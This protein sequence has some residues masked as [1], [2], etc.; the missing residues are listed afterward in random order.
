MGGVAGLLDPGQGTH[1]FRIQFWFGFLQE[2]VERRGSREA[3]WPDRPSHI[4][5]RENEE[6]LVQGMGRA[7]RAY[8]DSRANQ[9]TNEENMVSPSPLQ[10]S[11]WL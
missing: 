3:S 11:E 4:E 5:R 10:G 8:R 1:Q 7:L 9:K 6:S 2:A